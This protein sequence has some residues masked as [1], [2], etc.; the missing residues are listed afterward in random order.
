MGTRLRK[1]VLGLCWGVVLSAA[2]SVADRA[3]LI[4]YLTDGGTL[5]AL[6]LNNVDLRY[7]KLHG[8]F[9]LL[10]QSPAYQLH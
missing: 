7:R 2:L 8:L 5:P 3:F 10:L 9:A 4:D 6:D 1:L